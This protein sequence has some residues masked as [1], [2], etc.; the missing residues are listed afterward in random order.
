[1]V[2]GDPVWILL[3]IQMLMCASA[4]SRAPNE[5]V[6]EGVPIRQVPSPGP[7]DARPITHV[8]KSVPAH[9]GRAAVSL[10]AGTAAA[11]GAR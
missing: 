6:T 7:R 4:P 8:R 9:A 1:M 10:P 11:G 5:E 2:D 3:A